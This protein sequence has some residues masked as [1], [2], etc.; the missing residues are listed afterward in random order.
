MKRLTYAGISDDN[1]LHLSV[2]NKRSD[3]QIIERTDI[4]VQPSSHANEP[5]RLHLSSDKY[6]ITYSIEAFA[7]EQHQKKRLIDI[8]S[9]VE[10]ENEDETVQQLFDRIKQTKKDQ[11]VA[12]RVR[13][14]ELLLKNQWS[15]E[16]VLVNEHNQVDDA[17][18]NEYAWLMEDIYELTNKATA[19]L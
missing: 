3:G 17:L 19:D 14:Q 1:D 4:F 18:N 15:K 2:F 7:I 10:I 12:K 16:G 6:H 8:G 5:V 13:L 9:L 11:L